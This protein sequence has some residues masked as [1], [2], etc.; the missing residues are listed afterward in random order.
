LP[1]ESSEN[2]LDSE[3]NGNNVGKPEDSH[4]NESNPDIITPVRTL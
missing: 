2:A 4:Q 1:T 3:F